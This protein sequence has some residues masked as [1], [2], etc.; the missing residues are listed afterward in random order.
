MDK[1]LYQ[2]HEATEFS[3]QYPDLNE[4]WGIGKALESLGVSSLTMA[5]GGN[6]Y[7]PFVLHGKLDPESS[8]LIRDPYYVD[9][10]MYYVGDEVSQ[11]F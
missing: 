5:H 8:E 7:C 2:I 6:N 11:I 10:K 4:Y 3:D 1:W 9:G